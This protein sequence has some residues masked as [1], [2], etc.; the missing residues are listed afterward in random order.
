VLLCLLT[1]GVAAH[2]L[3]KAFDRARLRYAQRKDAASVVLIGLLAIG[4]VAAGLIAAFLLFSCLLF[5]APLA[6][7]S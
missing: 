6:M 1:L 2:F 3:T 5:V 7:G 4:L